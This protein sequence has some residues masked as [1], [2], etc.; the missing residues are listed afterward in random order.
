MSDA[1]RVLAFAGAPIDIYL[2]LE[3]ALV[4][5]L[6]I[7]PSIGQRDAQGYHQRPSRVWG[8]GV[9]FIGLLYIALRE[10]YG[11]LGEPVRDVVIITLICEA[12]AFVW[13]WS[14]RTGYG[15]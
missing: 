12:W 6:R 4:Y 13:L 3:V 5:Q 11:N 9:S 14:L 2:T 1:L 7:W 15:R 10:V 8:M